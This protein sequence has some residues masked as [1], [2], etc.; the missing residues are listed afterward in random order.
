[1]Y[2]VILLVL[3]PRLFACKEVNFKKID[4]ESETSIGF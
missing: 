4:L 2:E 1:M 3:V